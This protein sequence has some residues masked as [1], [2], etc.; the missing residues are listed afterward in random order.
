MEPLTNEAIDELNARMQQLITG[1]AGPIEARDQVARE[2]RLR[3]IYESSL[4]DRVYQDSDDAY[5][6][7]EAEAPAWNND[8]GYHFW[9]ED[10]GDPGQTNGLFDALY[11]GM[12]EPQEPFAASFP[13]FDSPGFEVE[14]CDAQDAAEAAAHWW[15][16]DLEDFR[17]KRGEE[18]L[19]VT[20][21][22]SD[23][24]ESR[25]EV[26]GVGG[27]YVAKPMEASAMGE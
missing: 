14:G 27:H 11:L 8:G 9:D 13:D 25:W 12:V 20:L 21:T 3:R 6:A 19:R 17:V 22:R 4:G 7:I 2:F 1:G 24:Q 23:G 16:R 15:E 26:L 18:T 10:G 5:C